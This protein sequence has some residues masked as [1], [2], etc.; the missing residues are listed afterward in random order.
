MLLFAALLLI[1]CLIALYL[2]GIFWFPRKLFR[3]WGDWH[4]RQRLGFG[5]VAFAVIVSPYLAFKTADYFSALSRVPEPL[6]AIFIEYRVEWSGGIGPGANET[7]FVVYRLTDASAAWA[8]DKGA[9][10]G[11]ALGGD[12]SHWL[13]TPVDDRIE[14]GRAWHSYVDHPA[15]ADVA[16][17]RSYLDRYGFGLPLENGRADAFNL[18][19]RTPGSFYTY[20]VGGAITVVDPQ[21]GKV[22][23]AY[24]G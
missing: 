13:E 4:W 23:F 5:A 20:G 2:Y 18:V 22:Y 21:H 6:R 17:I 15:T 11:A 9:K 10:L 19:I 8:R 24:A 12:N 3:K 7:G 14:N 16:D 1:L